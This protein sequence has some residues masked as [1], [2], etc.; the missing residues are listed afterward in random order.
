MK[1]LRRRTFL[2]GLGL[3]VSSPGIP[4]WW[5]A[6]KVRSNDV[7]PLIRAILQRHLAE[8]P[9]EAGVIELFLADMVVDV[10]RPGLCWLGMAAPVHRRGRALEGIP[11]VGQ[12]LKRV[13][14]WAVTHFMLSTDAFA[15]GRPAEQPLRYVGYYDPTVAAAFNPLANLSPTSCSE[16]PGP[17]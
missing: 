15:P 14:A 2:L 6:T 4:L 13:E 3:L 17:P 16:S 10:P 11:G 7:K 12:R 9:H 1:H 5:W 8:V